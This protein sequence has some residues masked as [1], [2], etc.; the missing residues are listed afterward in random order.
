[1]PMRGAAIVWVL[2]AALAAA[3]PACAATNA[4]LAEQVREAERSF[5]KTMAD[6]DHAAFG[7][8]VAEEAIFFGRAARRGRAAVME[9]WKP[10]FQGESA[11]FSWEPEIV[12]VLDSGTLGLSTGPVRDPD[13][14][15]T[16]TFSSIWRLEPDGRWRVVFDRGCPVCEAQPA[17]APAPAPK[18][19]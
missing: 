3:T 6:R 11:P 16:G 1:M 8:F 5:A 7:T 9:A 10:F 13:G 15:V 18:P 17:P 14:K 4:D 12:V 19:E 2:A